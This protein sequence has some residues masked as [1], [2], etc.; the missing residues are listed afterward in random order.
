MIVS[1]RIGSGVGQERNCARPLDGERE[2]AL[3]PGAV[4]GD[5]ARND[6]A[7]FGEE[8][9]ER[10]R[11]LVVDE[12]RLVGAEATDLPPPHAAAAEAAALAF[13]ASPFAAVAV[14]VH[15]G[16]SSPMPSNS[17]ATSNSSSRSGRRGAGRG[18]AGGAFSA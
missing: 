14:L 11:V 7:A 15:H 12:H 16:P 9:P 10:A 4:A 8:V 5:A 13:T 17:A 3:M 2:S 6:L 18:G 1:S